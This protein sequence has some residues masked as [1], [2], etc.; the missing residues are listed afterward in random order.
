MKTKIE[1]KQELLKAL[2]NNSLLRD[3]HNPNNLATVYDKDRSVISHQVAENLYEFIDVGI[4]KIFEYQNKGGAYFEIIL[5]SKYE[6]AS[7]G[8][9]AYSTLPNAGFDRII[10]VHGEKLKW[11]IFGEDSKNI[12]RDFEAGKL[13]DKI[14]LQ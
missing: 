8:V 11:H 2:K 5:K 7:S 14:E 3:K 4:D 12:Q 10:A 1:L 13:R 9:I 6:Y